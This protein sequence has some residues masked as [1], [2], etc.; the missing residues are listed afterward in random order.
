MKCENCKL[1][2]SCTMVWR[3][4]KKDC[5]HFIQRT[6]GDAIRAMSDEE[7]AEFLAYTWATSDRAWQKEPGETLYWLKQPAEEEQHET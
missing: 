1:N 3:T 5:P 6:N 7:L 4:S 2:P